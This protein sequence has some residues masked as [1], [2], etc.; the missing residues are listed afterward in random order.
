MHKTWNFHGGVHPQENKSQSNEPPIVVMPPPKQL[1]VPLNQ[2]IGKVDRAIVKV[3]DYVL[4]GQLIA[5]AQGFVSTNI[6]APSSGHVTALEEHILPHQ[7]ALFG[8]CIIINT[9]GKDQWIELS[10][11]NNPKALSKPELLNIIQAAGI[12]GLDIG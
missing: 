10:P 5:S 3:G 12:A 9:D 8:P 7:S 11:T 2:H 1:I 6:H 4:K